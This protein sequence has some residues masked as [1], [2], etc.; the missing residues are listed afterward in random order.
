ML[1]WSYVVGPIIDRPLPDCVDRNR[2][3]L[4]IKEVSDK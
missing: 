4:I 1:V 2:T 3:A